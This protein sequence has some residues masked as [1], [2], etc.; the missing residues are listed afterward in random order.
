[1]VIFAD[2]GD[3]S[4]DEHLK[5]YNELILHIKDSQNVIK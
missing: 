1:M 3:K 4:D 2:F 5:H